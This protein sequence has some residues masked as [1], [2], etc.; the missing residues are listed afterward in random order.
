VATKY[1]LKVNDSFR[2]SVN[3]DFRHCQI[4]DEL[5]FILSSVFHLKDN[6]IFYFSGWCTLLSSKG[7]SHVCLFAWSQF[8]FVRSNF[9]IACFKLSDIKGHFDREL[10]N[11]FVF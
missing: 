8:D 6:S 7:N 11:I 3:D 5:Q 2:I 9:E 4:A 1:L 10:P